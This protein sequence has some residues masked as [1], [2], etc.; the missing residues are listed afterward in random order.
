[1]TIIQESFAQPVKLDAID[2]KI[3]WQ[4]SLNSRIPQTQLA[5]QL[6]ISKERLHYKINRLK[7]NLIDPAII[8]NY[9]SLKIDSYI[10][11]LKN[12][13]PSNLEKIKNQ[14]PS[15]VIAQSLGKYNY[16]LYI[17]TKDVKK[18]TQEF[19][20]SSH[21]EIYP[22]TAG[23]PDNY[24]PYNL[25]VKHPELIKKDL[26]INL[27]KKDYKLLHAL[28]LDPTAPTLKISEQTKLDPKTIKSRIDKM[29][30]ANLIQKFRFAV[31]VLKMGV[32][33]YFL[34]IETTPFLKEKILTTLR[35]NNYSGFVYETHIGFFMWYMPPSHT[36]LFQ[37]T[38]ALQKIDPTIEVDAMQ[39]AEIIK[40]ETVPKEVQQILKLRSQ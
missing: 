8:L 38:Q 9:Q 37:F 7:Q 3:F 11:L 40:I 34:K 15:F 33:A 26:P 1:M 17:L 4:L 27:D 31:N 18:F 6:K 21:F 19:L 25:A 29:L 14:S 36:E 30:E 23:Y 12:L 35:S 24:N 13:E 5:K 16:I 32:T 10:I 22:I 39:T 20:P 2:K 28:S